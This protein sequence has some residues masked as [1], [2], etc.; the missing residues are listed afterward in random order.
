MDI[1]I[2]AEGLELTEQ[3]K[4]AIQSKIG[5]VVQYAPRAVRA[6]VRIRKISARPSP[7]QYAVHV[8]CELPQADLSAEE[9]GPDPLSTLDIVAEK[10]E[11]RLRKRKTERLARRTRRQARFRE[12][13]S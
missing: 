12:K 4:T 1:L 6:R 5:R 2:H 8:L 3:M 13:S 7:R 10:I 9:A 11:R